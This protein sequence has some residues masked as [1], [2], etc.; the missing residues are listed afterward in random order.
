M[1][2]KWELDEG[3]TAIK[4]AW[5]REHTARANLERK[6][7]NVVIENTKLR[8]LVRYAYECAIHSDHATCDDC[9]RMNSGCI[10]VGR[11]KELGVEP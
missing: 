5:Q 4:S 10:L 11:M 2:T 7:E 6:L 1:N 8:E 9:K 3:I